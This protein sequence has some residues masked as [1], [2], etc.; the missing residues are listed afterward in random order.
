MTRPSSAPA[1]PLR[2]EA[3]ESRDAQGRTLHPHAAWSFGSA[4]E[5]SSGDEFSADEQDGEREPDFD[6]VGDRVIVVCRKMV[7]GLDTDDVQRSRADHHNRSGSDPAGRDPTSRNRD[8]GG[9]PKTARPNAASRNSDRDGCAHA[10]DSDGRPGRFPDP[11]SFSSSTSSPAAPPRLRRSGANTSIQISCK[12]PCRNVTALIPTS[13]SQLRRH[14]D[15]VPH[16]P[17]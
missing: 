1:P 4:P 9:W 12:R 14:P 3:S 13:A 2:P 16:R 8:G 10:T 17:K 6:A 15:S 11:S 5:P 7:A